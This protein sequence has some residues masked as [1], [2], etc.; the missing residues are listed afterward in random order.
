MERVFPDG[1]VVQN[2]PAMQKTPVRFLGQEDL[3]EK[4]LA[5][6][7]SILGHPR[8]GALMLSGTRW[9]GVSVAL[10]GALLS[11]IPGDTF[12]PFGIETEQLWH[13]VNHVLRS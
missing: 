5:T 9:G 1:P 8:P 7:S 12:S 3:L 4:G 6:H 13:Q 2:L 11:L 10:R